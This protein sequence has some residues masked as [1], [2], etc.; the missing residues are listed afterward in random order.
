MALPRIYFDYSFKIYQTVTLDEASSHH[1]FNVLRLKIGDQIILFNGQGGEYKAKIIDRQKKQAQVEIQEFFDIERQSPLKIHLGQGIARGEKMDYIVQKAVELGVSKI[2]PL[3]TEFSN[4]KLPPDRLE[5]KLQHWR[6]IAIHACEQC[7]RNDLPEIAA[8]EY[9]QKWLQN[10][11]E[12]LKLTLNPSASTS[13]S[14]LQMVS[15]VCLLIGSEGGLSA[16]EIA[17]A[18]QHHFQSLQLGPRILRTETASLAV[19]SALQMLWGDWR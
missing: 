16:A 11:P 9:A 8:P 18:N 2:T 3:F 17:L 10:R 12:K 7:G 13:L 1:L 19:L 6:Q 15:S 4:V 14:K 5:K